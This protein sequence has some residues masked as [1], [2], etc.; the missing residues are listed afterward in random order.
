MKG[1]PALCQYFGLLS[2]HACSAGVGKIIASTELSLEMQMAELSALL[3]EGIR[4][5]EVQPLPLKIYCP[6]DVPAAFRF[7]ASGATQLPFQENSLYVPI[8][9]MPPA[10][11]TLICTILS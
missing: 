4:S 10:E 2:Q 6:H 7:M 9:T 11:P 8:A 5:G 3:T 1:S